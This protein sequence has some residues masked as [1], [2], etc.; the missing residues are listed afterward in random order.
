[1]NEKV[2]AREL[3]PKL[4]YFSGRLGF[5]ET[6]YT[7]SAALQSL[8]A[9]LS[10]EWSFLTVTHE[11][12]HGHVRHLLSV[13][14]QG[15]L[16]RITDDKWE[17][18]YDR[19]SAQCRGEK[20]ADEGLLDSLRAII[21]KYCCK[22]IDAGSL[23]AARPRRPSENG[24][25]EFKIKLPESDDLR[26]VLSDEFRN[27][28][29]IL[30]HTLDLH[31][32]YRSCLSHYIPLIWKSWSKAPQVRA[33]LR[34]YLLRSLLVIAARRQGT[35]T[36]RFKLSRAYLEDLLRKTNRGNGESMPV[37][38]EAVSMLVRDYSNEHLFPA[39]QASLILAD[40]ADHVLMS[41]KIRGEIH[42]DDTHFREAHDDATNEEWLYYDMPEG[43]VDDKVVSPTAFIADRLTN[44]IDGESERDIEAETAAMFLACSSHQVG[45]GTS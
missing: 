37:I 26:G 11:M 42:K 13:I 4:P 17:A 29:E 14:F 35:P 31:Y 21:L 28:C 16:K 32:F 22:T 24:K 45:G 25:V 33:D 39:F 41:T 3:C 6:E 38:E 5:R 34:Q 30:V 20:V 44:Q 36:A 9:G 18:F 7:I 40:L 19:F 8:S 43:F 12:V 23:T 1:M 10:A 15:D 2:G 27:V